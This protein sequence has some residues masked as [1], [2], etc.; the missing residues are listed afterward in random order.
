MQEHPQSEGKFTFDSIPFICNRYLNVHVDAMRV[1]LTLLPHSKKMHTVAICGPLQDAFL[2]AAAMLLCMHG[3]YKETVTYLQ[4]TI[5]PNCQ[6]QQYST[7]TF[8]NEK[9]LKVKYVV[10]FLASVGVTI[11][12]AETWR[13]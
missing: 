8:A 12:K 10:H 5:A 3:L 2:Q 13:Q 1:L 11:D 9:D 6:V 4:I 7:T